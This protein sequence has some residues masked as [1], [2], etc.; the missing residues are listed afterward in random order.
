[1]NELIQLH[2]E[3]LVNSQLK[4]RIIIM[5][6]LSSIIGK[7]EAYKE[8]FLINIKILKFKKAPLFMIVQTM[9]KEV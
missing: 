3:M 2:I 7:M 6:F 5:E 4:M 8:L 9:K 1:M